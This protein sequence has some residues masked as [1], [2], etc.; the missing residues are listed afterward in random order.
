MKQGILLNHNMNN[1]KYFL[2]NTTRSNFDLKLCFI[3]LFYH[4]YF[5][6]IEVQLNLHSVITFMTLHLSSFIFNQYNQHLTIVNAV[7]D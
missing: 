5:N 1:N 2:I 7:I 4:F 3:F 6:E